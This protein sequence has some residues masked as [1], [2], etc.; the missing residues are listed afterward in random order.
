MDKTNPRLESIFD[1]YPQAQRRALSQFYDGVAVEVAA[2]T[3]RRLDSDG[4]L[5]LTIL[6]REVENR[7]LEAA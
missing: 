1:T 5:E 2:R 6:V 7:Y 3:L 4:V